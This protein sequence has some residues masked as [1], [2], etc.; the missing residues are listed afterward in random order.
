MMYSVMIMKEGILQTVCAEDL[1]AFILTLD[2]ADLLRAFHQLFD[3][4]ARLKVAAG[5]TEPTLHA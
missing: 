2:Q 3:E 1:D 4:L 5:E